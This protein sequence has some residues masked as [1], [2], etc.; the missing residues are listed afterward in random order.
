MLE[1]CCHHP[2]YSLGKVKRDGYHFVSN[3]Y[4]SIALK[5][6]ANENTEKKLK[7]KIKVI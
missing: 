6:N 7:R 1:I 2:I 3:G 5:F 4:L